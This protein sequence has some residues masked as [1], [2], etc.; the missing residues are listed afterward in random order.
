MT[1][2][3]ALAAR[4]RAAGCVFAED[5]ADVVMRATVDP[6]ERELLLRR[7]VAG[8]PLEHV[9]G[10]AEFCGIRVGVRDRVFVPRRRSEFLA[11]CAAAEAR[12]GAT[13]LDMCCGTGA[14]GLIATRNLR[15][16][17]L[18]AVDCD[19]V[20]IECAKEN[21]SGASVYL[22]DLFGPLPLILKGR[23]DVIVAVTPYV[24]TAELAFLHREARLYEPATT[25]D[26]GPDGLALTGRILAEA[27]DW[28]APDGVVLLEV[29][30]AQAPAAIDLAGR[31]GLTAYVDRDEDSDA[32][33]VIARVQ[34]GVRGRGRGPR[35]PS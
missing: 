8:A 2:E 5:E 4:L 28:L 19:P 24:P 22:G 11:R 23:V 33:V 30:D 25:H 16:V 31:G 10:W 34:P 21:L 26:G 29:S 14:I 1:G 20:A 13:V 32:T 7:R 17:A 18:H 6:V 15:D 9:V 12:E 35:S 3:S 27:R